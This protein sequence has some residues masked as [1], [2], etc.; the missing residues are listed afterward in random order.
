MLSGSRLISDLF[1]AR[2]R[3]YGVTFPAP[4][5]PFYRHRRTTLEQCRT[6]PQDDGFHWPATVVAKFCGFSELKATIQT[7]FVCEWVWATA[8]RVKPLSS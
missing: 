7:I 4:E 3:A 6:F 2:I 5:R 8:T 1:E